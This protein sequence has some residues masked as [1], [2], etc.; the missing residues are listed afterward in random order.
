M[1]GATTYGRTNTHYHRIRGASHHVARTMVA[2]RHVRGR[3]AAGVRLFGSQTHV[4]HPKG[5][6]HIPQ[7]RLFFRR[8]IAFGLVFQDR[9]QI[10]NLFG[11][12]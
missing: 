3:Q 1:V 8:E 5:V 4:L 7:H 10:D 9:E 6:K 11:L 2:D 12:G